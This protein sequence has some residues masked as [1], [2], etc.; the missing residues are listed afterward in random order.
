MIESLRPVPAFGI[1]LLIQGL[2]TTH[3]DWTFWVGSF[4]ILMSAL[5]SEVSSQILRSK[6]HNDTTENTVNLP[7]KKA[8]IEWNR[9]RTSTRNSRSSR[10]DA[11]ETSL[12]LDSDCD[13][14]SDEL[15]LP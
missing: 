11:T 5:L 14:A 4:V 8:L 7:C 3:T 10:T 6:T 9:R 13:E 12:L 15:S 2:S 1:L